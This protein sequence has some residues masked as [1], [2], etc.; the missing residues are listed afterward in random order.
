VLYLFLSLFCHGINAPNIKHQI[1][2][3]QLIQQAKD[4]SKQF[5]KC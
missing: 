3:F 1:T 5:R 4:L 2:L